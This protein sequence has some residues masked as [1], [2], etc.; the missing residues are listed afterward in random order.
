MLKRQH[1]YSQLQLEPH[2]VAIG[3]QIRITDG[4]RLNGL[5]ETRALPMCQ[6]FHCSVDDVFLMEGNQ[7]P[8]PAFLRNV[9][10]FRYINLE[11]LRNLIVFQ[12]RSLRYT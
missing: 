3:A 8:F 9:C 10:D 11:D 12:Y 5:L 6:P 4:K 7:V 2:G 1:R